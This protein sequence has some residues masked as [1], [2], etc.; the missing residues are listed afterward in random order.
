MEILGQSIL[1]D[2]IVF[3]NKMANTN[4]LSKTLLVVLSLVAATTI[5][6]ATVSTTAFAVS[7][8]YIKGWNLACRDD[9]SRTL[10]YKTAPHSRDFTSGYNDARDSDGPC[11]Y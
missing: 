7:K 4:L 6:A 10:Y 5:L 1:H 11:P 8:A 3:L 2:S 9:M